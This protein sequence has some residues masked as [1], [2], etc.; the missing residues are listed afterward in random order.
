MRDETHVRHGVRVYIPSTCS[1]T[2]VLR[3]VDWMASL[4]AD[5][6]ASSTRA[7]AD[8]LSLGKAGSGAESRFIS[9]IR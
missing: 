6:R 3:T 9:A 2:H 4:K 5:R 8:L 7:V 1:L